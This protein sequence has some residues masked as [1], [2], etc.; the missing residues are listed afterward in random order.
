MRIGGL[1]LVAEPGPCLGL[2]SGHQSTDQFSPVMAPVGEAEELEV[3]GQTV[4]EFLAVFDGLGIS[5]ATY[6][7]IVDECRQFAL[8]IHDVGQLI[9]VTVAD[10]VV[11]EADLAP[12]RVEI[13]RKPFSQVA[14]GQCIGGEGDSGVVDRRSNRIRVKVNHEA[15]PSHKLQVM[16]PRLPESGLIV[17]R[18]SALLSGEKGVTLPSKRSA[19]S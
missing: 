16:V 1:F 19:S 9:P 14:D 10:G 4:Y 13:P 2:G 17:N 3:G 15:E 11:E 7:D 6:Y 5:I 12:G 8:G 18:L